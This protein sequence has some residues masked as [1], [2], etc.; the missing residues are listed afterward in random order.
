MP[1]PVSDR[2]TNLFSREILSEKRP[3]T[4]QIIGQSPLVERVLVALMADGHVLLEGVPGLA[5]T[6]LVKTAS[7]VG[8]VNPVAQSRPG[9][10][11]QIGEKQ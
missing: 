8:Y 5:K 7:G 1:W 10:R 6:L 11:P 4:T 3:F 9:F 2:A